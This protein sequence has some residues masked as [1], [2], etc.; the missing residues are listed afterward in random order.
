MRASNANT[1]VSSAGIASLAS[2]QSVMAALDSD[3][4]EVVPIGITR[5]G[6]WLA[7]GDPMRELLAAGP[8]PDPEMSDL[9]ISRAYRFPDGRELLV[10]I[11]GD[12]TFD[13]VNP[14]PDQRLKV[15]FPNQTYPVLSHLAG[16]SESPFAP[17]YFDPADL[18]DFR[19]QSSGNEYQLTRQTI[20]LGPDDPYGS[21]W[22]VWEK[23]T[24]PDNIV[25]SSIAKANG[26]TV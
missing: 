22:F 1:C 18:T 9:T 14:G 3:A 5:Q 16:P 4:Y 10:L 11:T 7:G 6:Q 25:S 20:K 26:V 8:E 19:A 23:A 17:V 21:D 12:A 13:L 2:A 15:G 24:D